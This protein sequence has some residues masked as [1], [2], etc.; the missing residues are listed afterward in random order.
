MFEISEISETWQL[1]D[2]FMSEISETPEIDGFISEIFEEWKLIPGYE[3]HEISDQ[4]RVMNTNTGK[5]RKL[6]VKEGK[7]RLTITETGCKG[8]VTIDNVVL[9]VFS[10]PKNV[11]E[12]AQHINGNRLDNRLTNLRWVTGQCGSGKRVRKK[13]IPI[14][15]G[16]R[17]IIKELR[18][19]TNIIHVSEEGFVKS[20]DGI[21]RSGSVN[22]HN[23]YM[24]LSLSFDR[25]GK[26]K[27][28]LDGAKIDCYQKVHRLV[29]EAFHGPPSDGDVCHHKDKNKSNNS[30]GNLK[31]VTQ[32][33]NY[34]VCDKNFKNGDQG[35]RKV[36]QFTSDGKFVKTFDSQTEAGEAMGVTCSAIS[37]G[38]KKGHICKGFIWRAHVKI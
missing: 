10:R 25:Y 26:P 30:S 27:Y 9:G 21:W 7:N 16:H 6:T 31:W 20:G 23:G 34:K 29:C 18:F 35:K 19:G 22:K 5:I 1:V 4:G 33:L 13:K 12:H 15:P 11:N 14:C 36:D 28:N 32:S 38:V 17:S 37:G 24:K 2:G 3:Y 8:A